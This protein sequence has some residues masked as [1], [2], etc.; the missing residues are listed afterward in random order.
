MRLAEYLQLADIPQAKF[1][2][3]V[4]VRQATI[5]RYLSGKIP[6]SAAAMARILDTSRGAVAVADWVPQKKPRRVAPA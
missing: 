2:E 1:G 3:L 5:S 6:P 4:G